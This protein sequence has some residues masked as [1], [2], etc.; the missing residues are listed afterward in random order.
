MYGAFSGLFG[1]SNVDT[2]EYT[3]EEIAIDEAIQFEENSKS[4][5]K[6]LALVDKLSCQDVTKDN[7]VYEINF[8]AALNRLSYWKEIDKLK[9]TNKDKQNGTNRY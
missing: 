8:I 4:S 3:D 9:Q 2:N 7:Q 6:W 1:T 5:F